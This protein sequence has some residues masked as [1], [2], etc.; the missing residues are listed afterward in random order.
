MARRGP[1]RRD[2]LHGAPWR[3]PRPAGGTRSRHRPRHHR[4]DELPAAGGARGRRR[5]CRSAPG[6]HRALCAGPRLPQGSAHPLAAPRR[7]DPRRGRRV[8]LSRVHRQRAGARGGARRQGRARLARQ[9]HAAPH[10]RPGLVVLPGRDLHRS[11]AAADAAADGALR[12]LHRVPRR[13]SH[14]RHRGAVRARCAPLHFVPDDRTP[15]KHSGGLAAA[16]RQS[17]LRLRRLPARVPVEPLRAARDRTGFRRAPRTRR[18]GT[19]G[20]VPVDRSRIRPADGRQ[21]HPPDR[22]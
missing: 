1:P 17:R 21:R 16:R 8:R 11:A 3:D 22:L 9:A 14:R 20:A 4:A 13:L 15:G 18:H 10:A 7:D 6:V 12:H 5:A 2:G 19:R